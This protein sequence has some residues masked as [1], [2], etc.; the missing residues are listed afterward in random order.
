MSSTHEFDELEFIMS[1]N[2]SVQASLD[3]HM[4]LLC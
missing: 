4:L 1:L 2:I 3:A